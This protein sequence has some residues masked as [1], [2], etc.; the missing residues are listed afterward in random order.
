MNSQDAGSDDTPG[1]VAGAAGELP[2]QGAAEPG[3]HQV[4]RLGRDLEQ[5]V[6]KALSGITIVPD[7]VRAFQDKHRC[8]HLIEAMVWPFG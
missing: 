4:D 3:Q 6:G 2:W 1:V 7:M 5:F 8:R